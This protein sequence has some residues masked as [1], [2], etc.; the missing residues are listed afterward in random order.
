LV[1]DNLEE[2]TEPFA[3]RTTMLGVGWVIDIDV[4]FGGK[5]RGE[6]SIRE[7]EHIPWPSQEVDEI[8]DELEV[9]RA[10]RAH[11]RYSRL[12]AKR[13]SAPFI[14]SMP[15]HEG[16]LDSA[17]ACNFRIRHFH[18]ECGADCNSLT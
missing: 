11:I 13:G 3:L 7:I 2:I 9:N 8:V 4:K 18:T 16:L 5:E 15:E 6:A 14:F 12:L 1:V 17:T 10:D